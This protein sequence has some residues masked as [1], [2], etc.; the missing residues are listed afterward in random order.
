MI[1]CRFYVDERGSRRAEVP[2]PYQAFGT[3]LE[4]DVQSLEHVLELLDRTREV[5][6]GVRP[7]WEEGGNAFRV[8][9]RPDR[10]Q[11]ECEFDETS[12]GELST[13][14]YLELLKGWSELL[15]PDVKELRRLEH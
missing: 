7:S 4:S 13:E 12:K 1:P 6:S 9:I 14:D 11:W 15:A 5:I 3:Y 10:V 8:A 2:S